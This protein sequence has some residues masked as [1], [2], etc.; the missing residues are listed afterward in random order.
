MAGSGGGAAGANQG[1]ATTCEVGEAQN[2]AAPGSLNLFGQIAY[3]DLGAA[4]PAGHYRV[5]YVDGCGKYSSAQAWA[6]HAYADGSIAWWLGSTSGNKLVLLPGTSGIFEGQG[7][8]TDFEACV[9]A[10]ALLAPIEFDFAGGVLGV[11]VS[12]DNYYDNVAGLNGRNPVWK[13]TLLN[14]AC[15]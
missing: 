15:D 10:N 9:A 11:W 1:G 13:L 4:L 14:G 3:F 7:G 5:T 8:Y 6:I 2:P 12:D